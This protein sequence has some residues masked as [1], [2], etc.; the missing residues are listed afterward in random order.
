MQNV[1]WKTLL[2]IGGVCAPKGQK[3]TSPGQRPCCTT[4]IVIAIG[5]LERQGDYGS[6]AN[7]RR[8]G[9]LSQRID[10]NACAMGDRRNE[11]R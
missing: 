1:N 6:I 10:R 7:E 11:R 4:Q 8:E 3:H 5:D 2:R 9:E